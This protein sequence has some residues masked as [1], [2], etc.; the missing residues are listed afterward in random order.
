M[1]EVCS[2]LARKTLERFF[3]SQ[4]LTDFI[5]VLEDWNNSWGATYLNSCE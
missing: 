2:K 3:Y 1:Y 5:L 4:L